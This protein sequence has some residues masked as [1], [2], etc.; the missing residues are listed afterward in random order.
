M[1]LMKLIG[2]AALAC[3]SCGDIPKD[4]DGSLGRIRAERSFRVGLIASGAPLGA[5]RQA[6]FVRNVAAAAGA[7]PRFELGATEPLLTR[8]E[9]GEL[10]LVI[11]PMTP[12]SPWEKQVTFLPLL[13]EQVSESGHV[14]LAAMARHGENAW[15]TLLHK[16]AGKV[17]AAR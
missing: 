13:G 15:I 1:K 9:E 17:A 2:V 8:L 12:K 16:E 4:P 5:E 10:D 7:R 3:A 11:G 6:L 14:H